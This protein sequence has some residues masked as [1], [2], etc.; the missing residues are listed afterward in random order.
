MESQTVIRFW[1]EEATPSQW[2]RKDEKFDAEIRRRFLDVYEGAMKGE[3]ADWR[4]SPEGR[5]AE[6]IVLDQFPRNMFRNSPQAFA[7]DALALKFV[8][9]AIAAGDDKKL[10]VRM[11]R[12]LYMPYM[13]SESRDAHKKALRLFFSLLPSQ[14]AAFKFEWK[15]KRIIDRFGRYPSRNAI[16]RRESTPA[17][18]EFL[19]THKGF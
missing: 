9:D 12:F 11:R 4:K 18:T 7:G 8:Q 5:L 19:K 17:E 10:S 3:L 1:F 16:L 14:W 13:H 6:I 2:F 15:H